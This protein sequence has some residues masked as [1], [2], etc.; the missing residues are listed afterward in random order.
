MNSST[1]RQQSTLDKIARSLGTK[2]NAIAFEQLSVTG[3]AASLA[4]L[5]SDAT[6]AEV[7]VESTVAAPTYSI[8]YRIDGP[9]PTGS[10]GMPASMGTVFGIDGQENLK[11]FSAIQTGA[12]THLLSIT[13]FR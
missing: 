13:Y 4:S 3:T 2:P 7:I 12:G 8:R 11:K 9:L 6:Y 1:N 10:V 5:P